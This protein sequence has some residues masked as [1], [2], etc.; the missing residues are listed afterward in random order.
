MWRIVF[1]TI[2]GNTS[3]CL[4]SAGG[5]ASAILIFLLLSAS[6]AGVIEK[7]LELYRGGQIWDLVVIDSQ[8]TEEEILRIE[9]LKMIRSQPAVGIDAGVKG[10]KLQIV[11]IEKGGDVF[12][13]DTV[14]GHFP[15]GN[16][17][18]IPQ[19]LA[20][21][22]NSTIGNRIQA[23]F[24]VENEIIFEE[25][26]I[27][28]IFLDRP[29]ILV[30]SLDKARDICRCEYNAIFITLV[31]ADVSDVHKE[32]ERILH[33]EKV[34]S[35]KTLLEAIQKEY[36][37]TRFSMSLASSLVFL[38]AGIGMFAMMMISVAGRRRE[39]GILKALG[40]KSSEVFML[41]LV[42]S[43]TV[44]AIGIAIGVGIAAISTYLLNLSGSFFIMRKGMILEGILLCF[45]VSFLF[46][47][48]PLLV[49][50]RASVMDCMTLGGDKAV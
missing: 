25:F 15:E 49:A 41:F 13:F 38:V 3:R 4:L 45:V 39:I 19:M 29:R 23:S 28:G 32:I 42:E 10:G 48:Y 27:S 16:Q 37:Y 40:V 22:W 21:Q 20:A 18:M 2:K 14:E 5:V 31:G 30:V 33:P 8:I 43:M 35:Q 12:T 7:S 47:L 46:S 6:F 44:T 1:R 26:E 9:N 36:G 50:R 24:L 11:G 34:I 17:I